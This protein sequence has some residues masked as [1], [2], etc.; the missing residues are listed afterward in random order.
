MNINSEEH[1]AFDSGHGSLKS[2]AKDVA[3]FAQ[4]LLNGGTYGDRR[5]LSRASVTAMTTPQLAPGTPAYF[6]WRDPTTGA[7]V[8][9]TIR[10]GSYG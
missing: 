8:D 9:I 2:T 3:I 5:V 6:S 10:G 7:R 4:M 1:D